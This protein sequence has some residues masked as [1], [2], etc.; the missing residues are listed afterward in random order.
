MTVLLVML[1]VVLLIVLV[2]L[3]RQ[4]A[5]SPL[6]STSLFMFAVLWYIAPVFIKVLW[7]NEVSAVNF[8]SDDTYALYGIVETITLLVTLLFL[9]HARP[10]FRSIKNS[11]LASVSI[12][13]TFALLIAL[14]GIG[15]TLAY[16]AQAISLGDTYIARNAF[17]IAGEGTAQFD[18]VGSLALLQT[19]LVSFAYASLL[20]KW[21]RGLKTRR[22]YLAIGI[23]IV[24]A[25]VPNVLLGGRIAILVPF[26][27]LVLRGRA[28]HWPNKKMI[29]RVGAVLA[30]TAVFGGAVSVVVGSSRTQADLT[31]EEVV[32]QSLDEIGTGSSG[33]GPVQAVLGG[34]VTKFDSISWGA[35]LVETFGAESAGLRPYE[36]VLVALIPRQFL[37]SKPVPGSADGTYQGHPSRLAV[38]S[39]SD[40][41]NNVQ[42]SPAAIAIWQLG[43]WGIILLV[44]TNVI[45]LYVINSLLQSSSLILQSLALFLIGVPAFYTLFASPDTVLMNLQRAMAIYVFLSIVARVA[46]RRTSREQL[47]AR[48][49]NRQS[50]L[51]GG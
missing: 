19:L 35:S 50:S 37:S 30:L 8:L 46:K 49:A 51:S 33:T 4:P 43:Y 23:W 45:N 11:N 22:L 1:Q 15:V 21:P 6:L 12:S 48:N 17:A 5:V 32:S 3:M 20:V 10:Y 7:G 26:V 13:P 2:K 39:S 38:F 14:V 9:F 47:V 25:I 18:N 40:P 36:G 16:N 31:L 27:L 34:L 28:S 42:V 29:L 24:L 41:S 44:I